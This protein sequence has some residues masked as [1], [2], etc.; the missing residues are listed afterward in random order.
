MPPD[1]VR[2]PAVALRATAGDGG[3][4]HHRE[5][6]QPGPPHPLG[7]GLEAPSRPARVAGEVHHR[8][9]DRELQ[10]RVPLRDHGRPRQGR[11][12]PANRFE[13]EVI[14]L[15][16]E[17]EVA[18]GAVAQVLGDRGAVGEVDPEVD[19]VEPPRTPQPGQGAGL[20]RRER[21]DVAQG[22]SLARNAARPG[23]MVLGDSSGR[24]S[25]RTKRWIRSTRWCPT[26][27][28]T[29]SRRPCSS[30]RGSRIRASRPHRGRGARAPATARPAT[31]GGSLATIP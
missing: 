4:L 23:A 12:A 21:R 15:R 5:V 18:R 13:I 25:S 11:D 30:R 22:S 27:R 14:G 9:A 1:R 29:S 24:D 10:R 19:P 7:L 20:R 17:V 16:E 26:A 31:S 2:I 8:A 3:E 6:A 28:L